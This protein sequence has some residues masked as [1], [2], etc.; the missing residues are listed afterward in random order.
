M[1]KRGKVNQCFCKSDSEKVYSISF[2]TRGYHVSVCHRVV[3]I[4]A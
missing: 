3:V 4:T 1:M 2:I